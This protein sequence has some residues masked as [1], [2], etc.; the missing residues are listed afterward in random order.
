MIKLQIITKI[1]MVLIIPKKG[2]KTPIF[3]GFLGLEVCE[4]GRQ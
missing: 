1:I 2:P 3:Q 4:Y